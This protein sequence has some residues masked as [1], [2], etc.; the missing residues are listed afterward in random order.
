VLR[1]ADAWK[2]V[3][4]GAVLFGLSPTAFVTSRRIRANFGVLT[5]T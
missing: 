3:V 1:P 2:A 5:S 4:R